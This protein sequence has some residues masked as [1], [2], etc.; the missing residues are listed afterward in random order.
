MKIKTTL[1]PEK[2]SI[3]Q[4]PHNF[5]QIHAQT[6]E[7]LKECF[8]KVGKEDMKQTHRMSCHL[9]KNEKYIQGCQKKQKLFF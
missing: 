7:Y 4:V 5:S 6:L 3:Y 8:E 9:L 2:G 1:Y